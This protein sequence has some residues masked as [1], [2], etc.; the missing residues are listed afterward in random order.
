[1]IKLSAWQAGMDVSWLSPDQSTHAAA[2]L[3]S[4]L[5]ADTSSHPLMH[6]AERKDE[7]DPV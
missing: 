1:M 3:L 4:C 7:I 6:V 2:Q 5:D